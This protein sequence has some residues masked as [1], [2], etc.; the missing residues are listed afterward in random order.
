MV[1]TSHKPRHQRNLVFAQYGD[2]L[3]NL[4]V[5]RQGEMAN[6]LC[7]FVVVTCRNKTCMYV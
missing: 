4:S 3:C 1:K 2:N 6:V 5:C 7:Y